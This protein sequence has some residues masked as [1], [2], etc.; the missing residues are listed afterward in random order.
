M[1]AQEIRLEALK[2]SVERSMN[3]DEDAWMKSAGKLADFI[4]GEENECTPHKKKGGRPFGS[5]NKPKD[6]S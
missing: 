3:F 5:K 6:K 1:E 4:I 2:L